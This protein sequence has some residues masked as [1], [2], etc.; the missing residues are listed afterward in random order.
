MLI[1]IWYIGLFNQCHCS[2]F[3]QILRIK[4]YYTSSTYEG[5]TKSNA[6]GP[7]GS[8]LQGV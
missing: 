1:Q 8:M 4:S 2:I 5:I 6:N 3:K 7:V